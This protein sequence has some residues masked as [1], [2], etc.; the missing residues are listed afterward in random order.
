MATARPIS[1]MML[2][3]YCDTSVNRA[4]RNVP[5]RPPRIASTPT[6]SGRSAAITDAKMITSMISVIGSARYSARCR[7]DSNVLLKA[8][9]IGTFPVATM[10]NG[11]G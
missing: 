5:A 10:V 8:R 6:P 3:A 1:V 9:L 4:R 7:S 11:P 2:I